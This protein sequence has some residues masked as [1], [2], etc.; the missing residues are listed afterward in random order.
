MQIINLSL[1]VHSEVHSRSISSSPRHLPLLN[2]ETGPFSSKAL[3][4]ISFWRWV[5]AKY[6]HTYVRRCKR[7]SQNCQ[8]RFAWENCLKKAKKRKWSTL[9]AM[10][11]KLTLR[12]WYYL[13][14]ACTKY[15]RGWYGVQETNGTCLL[16]SLS[17][18]GIDNHP[19][20]KFCVEDD[21][22]QKATWTWFATDQDA[23][24][25]HGIGAWAMKSPTTRVRSSTVAAVIT[26]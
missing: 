20:E 15:D 18:S 23:L 21:F 6:D 13:Y 7:N 26:V 11:S 10:A 14:E 8:S 2:N 9:N 19:K 24:N 25:T 22:E 1:R 12:A 4:F 17:T 3:D 5:E 16:H